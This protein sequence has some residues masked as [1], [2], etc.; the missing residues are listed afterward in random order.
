MLIFNKKKSMYDFYN[1]H[2]VF[3]YWFLKEHT[4][5]SEKLYYLLIR[6]LVECL[7]QDIGMLVCLDEREQHKW[8]IEQIE[9][10]IMQNSK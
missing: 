3:L 4:E 5:L 8:I 7:E 2:N 9:D 6:Y 1:K 10:F